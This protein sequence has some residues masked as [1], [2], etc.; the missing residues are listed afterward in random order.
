MKLEKK[1]KKFDAWKYKDR[2]FLE[3]VFEDKLVD[4]VPLFLKLWRLFRYYIIAITLVVV[5]ILI[6]DYCGKFWD[7]FFNG[8]L[9]GLAANYL[10][11]TFSK[12]KA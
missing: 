8:I 11:K 4:D 5:G 9:C 12:N 7:A 10:V 1:F 6:K 3:P 2:F